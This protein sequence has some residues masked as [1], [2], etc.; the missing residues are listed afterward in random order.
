MAAMSSLLEI[1]FAVALSA[2]IFRYALQYLFFDV[3]IPPGAQLPPSPRGIPILGNMLQVPQAHS[4]I[5]FK[6]WADQYGPL[7]SLSL[8]GNRHVVVSTEKI[9]NDLLRGRGNIY[10]SR[11]YLP[12]G[13]EILSQNLRPVLL[14]YN[15]L[16]RKGRRLMHSFSSE[17][18]ASAYEPIQSHESS[19][20]LKDLLAD[21]VNYEKWFERYSA[22]VILRL[23]YG[24][25][26]ETGDEENVREILEVVHTVE[27]VASP[28]AY[29]VDIFPILLWLPKWLAPFK[30]EGDRLHRRELDLFRRS[31]DDVRTEIAE[32]SQTPSFCRSWLEKEQLSGLSNDE[33]AYVIGTMFEA[34]SGTTTSAMLSFVLAM[35]HHPEWQRRLHQEIDA[36]VGNSRLPSFDDIQHLPITRAIVKETLRW[37]PVTAGGL[38]HQLIKDDIYEGIFLQA[39]TSIHPNQWAI[40]R[41]PTLY[42]DPESFRPERWLEPSWPTYREPLTQFPNL[43]NFSAFGFGRRICPGQSIAERSLNIAVARIGWGCTVSKIRDVEVPL[44]D[45]TTGFNVQPKNST[46]A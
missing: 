14:P 6:Q 32:G 22:G 20:M 42:P 35:V 8:A 45:Y 18:V 46:L 10:S 1:C 5:K 30:W 31:L 7:Y 9:A 26:V 19:R 38:P 17:A 2:F 43:Q 29:L 24:K 44:Y 3:H 36:V 21:P 25:T 33:A 11:P 37:R 27:R 4:W 12:M 15:D 39:G 34:G 40:H 13:A 28:G 16:W 41:D 23:A